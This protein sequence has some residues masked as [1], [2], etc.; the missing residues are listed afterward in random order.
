PSQPDQPDP[1]EVVLGVDTHKDFHVA[2][3]LTALGAV[4]GTNRFPT[5]A[6]GYRQLLDWART[7]G[8]VRRARVE[9]TGSYR[10]ALTRHLYPAPA[11][12]CGGPG[13]NARAPTAPRCPATCT[14][15]G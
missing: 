2:A 9:C 10:A 7:F 6:A 15:P 3:V 13:G 4:A 12:R 11:A 14:G 5:T 8:T 1:A